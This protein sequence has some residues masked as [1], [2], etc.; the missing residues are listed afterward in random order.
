MELRDREDLVLASLLRLDRV[1]AI[2]SRIAVSHVDFL[3]LIDDSK[4]RRREKSTWL[5]GR[6]L[7]R[8]AHQ[9]RATGPLM[10]GI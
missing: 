3:E 6:S 4:D 1:G 9:A 7:L 8:I 5:I 2:K 10:R